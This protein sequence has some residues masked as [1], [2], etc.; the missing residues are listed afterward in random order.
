[1]FTI[2]RVAAAAATNKHSVLAAFFDKQV[3]SM[4]KR[5]AVIAD[6]LTGAN[7]TGVQFAKQGL[8]TIVALDAGQVEALGEYDVV[9]IDTDSRATSPAEAM[10]KTAEAARAVKTGRFQLIYKKVDSTLR[11]NLGFEIEAIMA[12]CSTEF[13]LVAPAFPKNGRSTIGGYHLLKGVPVEATE[14]A[15]DPKCPVHESYIP[16]LLA[17][18]LAFKTGLVGIKPMTAGQDAVAAEIRKLLADGVR[19]IVADTWLD[20]Q[21]TMLA[22]AACQVSDNILW[23]GSAGLAEVLPELLGLTAQQPGTVAGDPVLTVAGSVSAVTRRQVERL[24]AQPG[25]WLVKTDSSRL[26]PADGRDEYIRQCQNQV[27]DALSQGYDVVI[28]SGY[29]D[30]VVK[31]TKEQGAAL[32]L[33]P[34]ETSDTVAA[35]LGLLVAGLIHDKVPLGGLVLTGGDTAV[36]ISRT[37]GAAGLK[38]ISEIAV[39]IP[40]GLLQGGLCHAMPV[41]TKAGAF[42]NEDALCL[43]V[44]ALRSYRR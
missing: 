11:G 1:M 13:A 2:S 23:V 31:A 40:L 14:I 12:E 27:K 29:D 28:T 8:S 33:T 9:V 6:D 24:A 5:I 3:K 7:D 15:R 35:R 41:V 25:V 34:T 16:Q 30:D 19:V 26:L 44:Q 43:A 22:A 39:G 20:E 42:G 18:Q 10:R 38:V 17:E 21:F 4:K 37:V 32:G 36:N